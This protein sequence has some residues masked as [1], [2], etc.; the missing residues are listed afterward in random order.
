MISL[1]A[2]N[3]RGILA[4]DFSDYY[5][6]YNDTD[7]SN[8]LNRIRKKVPLGTLMFSLTYKCNFNCRMCLSK[9][10]NSNEL[11]IGTIKQILDEAASLG[12]ISV[13]FSGGEVMLRKDFP[14]IYRY[15]V[16]KGLL[17]TVLTNLTLWD[18]SI[19]SLFQKYPPSLLQV[20]VY[21]L[22]QE[23]YEA[24]TKIKGSFDIFKRNLERLR[25]IARFR[26]RFMMLF[27]KHNETDIEEYMNMPIGKGELKIYSAILV[28]RN[29]G[30]LEKMEMIR[31]ERISPEKAGYLH[32][33]YLNSKLSFPPPRFPDDLKAKLACKCLPVSGSSFIYID[34]NGMCMLCYEI[35]FPSQRRR[36]VP[37]KMKEILDDLTKA[38]ELEPMPKEG[39]KC[40]DCSKLAYCNWCPQYAMLMM[41]K[42][43]HDPYLCKFINTF[44]A[45]GM[46][47]QKSQ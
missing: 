32:Y 5:S 44:C 2:K 17:I 20:S 7:K 33:K 14:E 21:G 6:L 16:N 11:D 26:I 42:I 30:N 25:K 3:T 15:A 19:F 47:K 4:E 37:G 41:G 23:T 8:I 43:T 40:L 31:K 29:D 22:S 38:K 24:V 13:I 12:T 10:I 1:K 34:T 36:Y 35:M 18:D 9:D 45:V 28:G 46:S 39:I 27:T